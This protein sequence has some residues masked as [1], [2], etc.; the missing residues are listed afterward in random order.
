MIGG[1]TTDNRRAPGNTGR[2]LKQGS[3]RTRHLPFTMT[4]IS[5]CACTLTGCVSSASQTWPRNVTDGDR[6]YLRELAG[7]T[8]HYIDTFISP[9]TGL[10]YDS[11]QAKD[12]TNTTNVGLYLT[13]VCM[14][15]KMG[16]ITEE[17]A[18]ARVTKIMDSLDAIEN[19]HR[20]YNNWMDPEGINRAAKPGPNNISDYNKLPAGII[21]VRQTFPQ[22]AA[23]CTAFLDEIPWEVF[24]EKESDAMYYEFDIVEKTVN[25]PV[26]YF[27]GEDK[28]LG[29]FLAIASGKVPPVTWDK[30]DLTEEERHG[31]SYYLHGWQGGGL[32][33]QF[34][35][36]LYLDTRGTTLGKSSANF[37]FAQMAHAVVE[38]I[39][40]WGWSACVAPNGGYLGMGG[41]VDEVVTPHA[42]ALAINVFPSEVVANLR[43]LET[44]G[45]REP[46]VV[47][48]KAE[49]FG[50]R[51]SVNWK[52]GQ[53]A[54]K[55]LV[56][57]QSMLFLSLVN[58]LEDGVLWK[59]FDADPMV[60]HGKELIT[61]YREAPAKRAEADAYVAG[62]TFEEPG[63]FIVQR[64]HPTLSLTPGQPI[65]REIWARSLSTKLVVE[66]VAAW[67][68]KD[69]AGA[70]V[71]KGEVAFDLDPRESR[72]IGTISVPTDNAA[73]GSSW[74]LTGR[75]SFG[76]KS[77]GISSESIFFPSWLLIEDAWKIRQGDDPSWSGVDLD[78]SGW[79]LARV[80]VRWEEDT[81]PDY[82]GTAWYRR[83]LDVTPDLLKRWGDKP[84]ALAMGAIDDADETFLNGTKIGAS[85][86]FPPEKETAYNQPRLYPIDRA[87]LKDRNVIAVRVSDWGG[88]GGI[89]RGPVA[90]GP[91]DELQR[92]LRDLE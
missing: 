72:K 86:A 79:F 43:R 10:P 75:P 21:V 91:E 18:L 56:L 26:Y 35:C 62:L 41:L 46:F 84:L 14:A 90:I 92:L 25:N 32:F 58:Y 39:P 16:L 55:F 5:L 51:D 30:Q 78:E 66:G 9:T 44:Y 34:I 3:M 63:I 22:L 77:P 83:S 13:A 68:V 15:Y 76:G 53:M 27:R 42:S 65:E 87:L 20:L 40:V 33:M 82:D 6:A 57:D 37:A 11:N 70:E 7:D 48:G 50:F 23:R 81:M 47:D 38:G 54:D 12:I 80:A 31:F 49:R 28:I 73:Y 2:A 60:R 29:H 59:T 61:E 17:H 69:G 85:G 19:W 64:G 88:N 89:W 24:H 45:L 8:W 52:N 36:D 71:A 4:T 67:T 74:T 1:S